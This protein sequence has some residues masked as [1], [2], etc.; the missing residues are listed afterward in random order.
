MASVLSRNSIFELATKGDAR[1]ALRHL[2]ELAQ[3]CPADDKL[4]LYSTFDGQNNLLPHLVQEGNDRHLIAL[5][6]S[7][8]FEGVDSDQVLAVLR[9][10]L[11][12][13][14]APKDKGMMEYMIDQNQNRLLPAL[15]FVGAKEVNTL[16]NNSTENRK[17]VSEGVRN[18]KL[19][20]K[21]AEHPIAVGLGIIA[22]IVTIL[23]AL[24][25]L[26]ND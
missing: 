8:S 3:N 5:F 15:N 18:E 14:Y 20:K 23:A 10:S 25:V 1:I 16:R 2:S 26:S 24:G 13:A 21:L 11:A 9:H 6:L 7:R 4:R 19:S 12:W 22:S 17:G